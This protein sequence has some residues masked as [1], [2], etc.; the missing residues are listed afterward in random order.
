MVVH[1]ADLVCA[2]IIPAKAN[3]PL[4]IDPNAVLTPPDPLGFLSSEALDHEA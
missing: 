3:P 1:D 4:L 2:T